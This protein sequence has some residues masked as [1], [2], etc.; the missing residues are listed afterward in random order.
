M[1]IHPY[2]FWPRTLRARV[3]A[4]VLLAVIPMFVL[5]LYTASVDRRRETTQAEANTLRLAG[6][7]ALEERQLFDQT[8]AL[9]QELADRP[10]PVRDRVGE[11]Q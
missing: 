6:L 11:H 1:A 8:R 10:G 9:L 2:P 3:I 4:V 7:I 5:T